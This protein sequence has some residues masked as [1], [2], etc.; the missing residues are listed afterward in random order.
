MI[1]P[2]FLGSTFH[3]IRTG[4][5]P[6]SLL[7]PRIR[8]MCRRS[9]I[10]YVMK[11]VHNLVQTQD[12]NT[13]DP[14]RSSIIDHY[15]VCRRA[16]VTIDMQSEF[17]SYFLLCRT[18]HLALLL[19]R[20]LSEG[21]VMW[22]S[23]VAINRFILG[24]SRWL[25][26]RCCSSAWCWTNQGQTISNFPPKCGERSMLIRQLH[27]ANPPSDTTSQHRHEW[28]C[29]L[30]SAR[31]FLNAFG[32]SALLPLAERSGLGAFNLA[33]QASNIEFQGTLVA[34]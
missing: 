20:N 26:L 7:G 9:C 33:I 2:S 19:Q 24:F 16:M 21:V 28:Y 30:C 34:L 1:G 6:F 32:L 27:T 10:C 3:I 17:V 22:S 4:R 8:H 31:V 15:S 29:R 11:Q 12:R 13:D 5:I 23:D 25:S 18:A 14:E